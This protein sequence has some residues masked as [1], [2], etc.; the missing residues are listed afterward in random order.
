MMFQEINKSFT[1]GH[2]G[3]LSA[4]KILCIGWCNEAVNYGGRGTADYAESCFLI[5]AT[6][7]VTLAR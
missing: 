5:P 3:R 4:S 6:Y 1:W 2:L 7:F